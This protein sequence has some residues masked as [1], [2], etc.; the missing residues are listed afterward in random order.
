MLTVGNDGS[1]KVAG[2]LLG[3]R[4]RVKKLIKLIMKKHITSSLYNITIAH[5]DNKDEANQLVELLKIKYQKVDNIPIFE[6]GCALGVHTGPGTL[7][8]GIQKI[9]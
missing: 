3:S 4:N 8:I 5:S 6:L 1:M 2:V 9:D 7:V